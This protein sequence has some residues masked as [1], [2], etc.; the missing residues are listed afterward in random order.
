MPMPS[1]AQLPVLR[2]LVKAQQS[3]TVASICFWT[4]LPA[5][6]VRRELKRLATVGMATRKTVDVPG[7]I[8]WERTRVVWSATESGRAALAQEGRDGTS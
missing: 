5:A 3:R 1:E 8:G 2:E 6:V 7:G 4:D